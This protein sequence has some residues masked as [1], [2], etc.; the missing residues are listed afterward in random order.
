MY[1]PVGCVAA[2]RIRGTDWTTR[3]RRHQ[4][5]RSILCQVAPVESQ[6][7]RRKLI[8]EIIWEKTHVTLPSDS[9]ELVGS[10]LVAESGDNLLSTSLRNHDK[11]RGHRRENRIHLRARTHIS[12]KRNRVNHFQK[13]VSN[14][15]RTW[16][17]ATLVIPVP[18]NNPNIK[19]IGMKA[20]W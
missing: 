9:L 13:I 4:T 2:W 16:R 7:R 8:I 5:E 6:T 12:N 18:A 3:G 20:D 17:I 10:D 15:G 14:I 11:Q 1:L 19:P